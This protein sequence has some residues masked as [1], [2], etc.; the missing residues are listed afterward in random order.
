MVEATLRVDVYLLSP[1]VN[2]K[3]NPQTMRTLSPS[4]HFL[5]SHDRKNRCFKASSK[6]NELGF[7]GFSGFSLA[8][9]HEFCHFCGCFFLII[10]DSSPGSVSPLALSGCIDQPQC[11][12]EEFVASETETAAVI[13][14]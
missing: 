10:G 1:L 8:F 2:R 5:P 4:K 12:R 3:W 7:H 13:I 14:S 9:V 6:K 11:I